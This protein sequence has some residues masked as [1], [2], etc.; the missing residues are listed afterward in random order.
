MLTEVSLQISLDTS[1]SAHQVVYYPVDVGEDNERGR[2]G[3][4]VEVLVHQAVPVV[5]PHLL[6]ILLH[7]LKRVAGKGCKTTVIFL[8]ILT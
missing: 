1:T 5:T 3:G 7:S 2:Q 4:L 8:K 6:R